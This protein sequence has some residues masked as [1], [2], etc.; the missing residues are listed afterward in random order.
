MVVL[1]GIPFFGV[2]H[3]HARYVIVDE[4]QKRSEG[5]QDCFLQKKRLLISGDCAVLTLVPLHFA[6][7]YNTREGLG[8]IGQL[9][10]LTLYRAPNIE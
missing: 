1:F 6:N 10:G 9:R 3:F 2:A 4:L 5:L 7:I 8:R